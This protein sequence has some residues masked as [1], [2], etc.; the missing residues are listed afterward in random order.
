[1]EKSDNFRA[2]FDSLFKVCFNINKMWIFKDI[3]YICK[4][5][6]MKALNLYYVL[7][8]DSSETHNKINYF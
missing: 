4:T 8:N 2:R 5:M 3:M 1:M 6:Q 7:V